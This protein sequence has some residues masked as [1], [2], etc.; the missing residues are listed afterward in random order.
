MPG[1]DGLTTASSWPGHPFLLTSAPP[2]ISCCHC[3]LQTSRGYLN[4][5]HFES[6]VFAW[7][8]LFSAIYHL[9]NFSFLRW[10][11]PVSKQEWWPR[12]VEFQIKATNTSKPHRIWLFE[13]EQ[14][15]ICNLLKS[16][17]KLNLQPLYTTKMNHSPSTNW[18]CYTSQGSLCNLLSQQSFLLYI[19]NLLLLQNC[20]LWG[21]PCPPIT[22]FYSLQHRTDDAI[23]HRN[24]PYSPSWAPW[25]KERIFFSF[26][27]LFL[28]QQGP[29][30][31]EEAYNRIYSIMQ[32]NEW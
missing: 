5:D 20:E 29:D 25:G 24:T 14:V 23:F 3:V 32:Y 22:I 6:Q 9:L 27:V 19:Y 21:K 16:K 26:C 12:L 31:H 2:L 10:K 18:N 17:I 8:L 13:L 15:K 28:T 11:R 1:Q 7:I 4:R 30:L